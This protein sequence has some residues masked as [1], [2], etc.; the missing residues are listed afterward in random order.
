MIQYLSAVLV[1]VGQLAVW[2][3]SALFV[4][5]GAVWQSTSCLNFCTRC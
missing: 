2:T 3:F 4:V 5:S 1:I